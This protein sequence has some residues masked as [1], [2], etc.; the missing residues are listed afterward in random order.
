MEVAS[1]A[2]DVSHHRLDQI[3]MLQIRRSEDVLRKS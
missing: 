3:Q 1:T 2:A